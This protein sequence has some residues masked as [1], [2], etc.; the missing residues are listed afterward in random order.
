MLFQSPVPTAG[1]REGF[2]SSDQCGKTPGQHEVQSLGEDA[3]DCS[4]QRVHTHTHTEIH[5]HT[6]TQTHTHTDTHTHTHTQTAGE[7]WNT[8][9]VSKGKNKARDVR[10]PLRSPGPAEA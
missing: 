2:R 5:T 9:R 3:G 10:L 7:C 8:P 4:I 6:Q 1:S